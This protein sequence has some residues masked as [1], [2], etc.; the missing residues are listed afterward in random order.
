M[1]SSASAAFISAQ[2]AA[3]SVRARWASP[4][5]TA[6]LALSSVPIAIAAPV[7]Q[8]IRADRTATG[9]EATGRLQVPWALQTLSTICKVDAGPRPS[10]RGE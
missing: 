6:S 4:K 8:L 3:M 1:G 2:A 9:G 5:C 10:G 7:A